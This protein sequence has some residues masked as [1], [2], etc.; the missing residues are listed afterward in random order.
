MKFKFYPTLLPILLFFS[1]LSTKS[2]AQGLGLWEDTPEPSIQLKGERQ[3]VPKVY[4]T[5]S[6][7]L[8]S[9]QTALAAAPLESAKTLRTSPLIMVFPM[10]NGTMQQFRVV[11][12]PIMEPGLAAK[13]PQIKTYLA[14]G[15][16][17]RTATM[18]FD[19]TTKGFHGMILSVEGATFIDPYSSGTT[20]EYIAY[21]KKD[22]VSDKEF[23][24]GVQ[25]E[26]RPRKT[27]QK[28]AYSNG[29]TLREYRFACAATGEYT[30]F[31]GGT[32]VD[33]MS[34]IT[35]T[36]NR[37]NQVYERDLAARLILVAN[38]NVLIYTNGA[39]DPFSNASA[40]ALIN[41]S[42]SEIDAQIGNAN[43]DI[44]HTVSTGGGGLAGLGVVCLTGQKG[45][46]ITGSGSPI[47]DPY[48]IDYVAHEVGHQFAGNHTFNG[49]TGACAG[50]N[51]N[52]GT[53]YEPGSGS[54]IQAYAGICS[55][56]NLQ[57]NSD[58]YFHGASLEEMISFSTGGAGNNCPVMTAT[59][60]T[61]PVA[62]VPMNVNLTIPANTPFE[63]TGAAT[64]ADG[65]ALTYCWEQ[66][67]LGPAGA[68][69][70]ATGNAPL[71]RSWSPTTDPVRTFPRLSNLL[72]NTV[73]L[74]ELMPTYTRSMNFRLSVRDNRAGG[75][76]V[77]C[78]SYAVDVDAAAGPF[79][80]TAPN[81]SGI[82]WAA[83]STETITW[84]VANTDAA[85]VSCSSVDILMST[86]GGN[87]FPT[88][89]VSGVSNDGSQTIVVPNITSSTVRIKVICSG[90]IFFDISNENLEIQF[91]GPDYT[92]TASPSTVVTCKPNAANIGVAITGFGGFNG[93]V[94]L[95]SLNLPANSIA[96]YTVKEVT[97][98]GNS[99]ISISTD[100]VA[101]GTYTVTIQ[102]TGTPGINTADIQLTVVEGVP[103]V[104]VLG[105][106]MN[107]DNVVGTTPTFSWNA[108]NGAEEYEIEIATDAAFSTIVATANNITGLNYT[109]ATTLS[110]ATVYFWRVK[111]SN[112][113]G[114]SEWSDV[115]IL[116]TE[117]V[118]ACSDVIAEGGFEAGPNSAW[119]ES[120]ALG[121][122]IVDNTS[123]VYNSGAYS[124]WLGGAS[125]ENAQIW[126][127]VT[128][129]PTAVSATL[130][131]YYVIASNE[132]AGDCTFDYAYVN[133]DGGAVETTYPL[134]SDNN[135]GGYQMATLDLSAHIGSTVEIRFQVTTDNSATSSF[136]LDDVA[137]EVCEAPPASCDSPLLIPKA[138]GLYTADEECTDAMGWTH[139][140]KKAGT[141]PATSTDVLLLSIEKDGTVAIAPSDVTVGV[142]AVGGSVDLSS[143]A[144]VTN[145]SGW[146][147]MNRYWDVTP[148]V[149]PGVAGVNVR[150]YYT[151][152][153]YDGIKT[154]VTGAG[155][156]M[157][158]HADLVFYK[159]ASGSGIN[160][161]PS[162]GH[163]GGDN[164]NYIEF[165]A[166]ISD[167]NI[168]HAAEFGVLGFSGGGG[169]AGGQGMGTG[170]LPIEL[171]NFTGELAKDG[172]LLRWTTAMEVENDYFVVEHSTDAEF[173]RDLG[174]VQGVINSTT[175]NSYE[176][177]H[178]FPKKGIH[179]YRLRQ[180]DLDGNATYSHIIALRSN[181][182]FPAGIQPNPVTSILTLNYVSS[183]ENVLTLSIFD[184]TG[185]LLR[186][187]TPAITEGR[188]LLD[189]DVS[190]L[191][192]GMYFLQIQHG[193]NITTERFIKL[194]E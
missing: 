6:L 188:N 112:I 19:I 180:V 51:R 45:R 176:Y 191:A 159:F 187:E 182:E 152:D 109:S 8:V 96:S 194:N 154:A 107:G 38:N 98:T 39:T 162:A 41:E 25:G 94:T 150:F 9:L 168:D 137:V 12:S 185:K 64:D 36:V 27:Y 173:F 29:S 50:G 17:D 114:A 145:P 11:E 171:L 83:G 28:N 67:D 157:T 133:V 59:G 99:V 62:T 116:R 26:L 75:G 37:V 164:T 24:C 127:N 174:Q 76:G 92:I 49:S 70:A 20:T 166:G 177:L 121:Y 48:D 60:N 179:F 135:T 100:D 73:P 104:P 55:P 57:S 142:T 21:Y 124:A 82:V 54:T 34:A 144:Y 22:F 169:G 42:Q 136:Y 131:Y 66:Y 147:V 126:Q 130:T 118:P 7:D 101:P 47:G 56:Q 175:P 158:S 140:W 58:P 189:Y 65:D 117:D 77:H 178:E 91:T 93:I 5:L 123:N 90:N 125:N 141:A 18:R 102:G 172:N 81:T 46:G 105:M 84:D 30:A 128:I 160:P 110:N 61:P 78:A 129:S 88:T 23:S 97:A 115:Y 143:A 120:S 80:V 74:G 183:E 165:P 2:Y 149:Q 122:V 10:P 44:G 113:C 69:E 163:T 68:P 132:A 192:E 167:Y 139:Y 151:S 103:D 181:R 111:S 156:N 14:Q 119:S 186:T 89:L 170:A 153:D 79:L 63:L 85:P 15:I 146:H 184:G 52:A 31:H 161:D 87:T 16:D 53:A 71:F 1:I 35:T 193:E 4:R 33:G 134:C 108:A 106:P 190:D 86:D 148:S 43:Y 40:G 3:I 138:V 72:T 32:V 13:F 155:G 95:E